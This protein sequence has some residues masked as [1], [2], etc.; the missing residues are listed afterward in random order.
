MHRVNEGISEDSNDELWSISSA[1][2]STAPANRTV[3]SM[4]SQTCTP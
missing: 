4:L 1:K 3:D 2:I